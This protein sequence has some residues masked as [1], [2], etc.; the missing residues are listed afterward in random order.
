[1]KNAMQLKAAVKKIAKER[2]KYIRAVCLAVLYAR[3]L[4]GKSFLITL[5][6]AF[7]H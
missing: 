5:Q 1:M 6:G 3:T 4:L 7:H 2:K